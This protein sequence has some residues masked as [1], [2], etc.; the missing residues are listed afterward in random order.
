MKIRLKGGIETPEKRRVIAEYIAAT[1][2]AGEHSDLPYKSN[3]TD[4]S[5]WTL[6]T[7]N[8]YFLSFIGDD[9]FEIQYRYYSDKMPA[10]NGICVWLSFRL[11]GEVVCDE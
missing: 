8:N 10:I 5:R 2:N 6:D 1:I 7:A 3:K 11:A 4:D 9:T